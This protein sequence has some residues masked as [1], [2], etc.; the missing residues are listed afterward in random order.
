MQIEE[1]DAW[2]GSDE[3]KAGG[4]ERTGRGFL[5]LKLQK[6]IPSF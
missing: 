3:W 5:H 2:I 1:R 4:E 6:L